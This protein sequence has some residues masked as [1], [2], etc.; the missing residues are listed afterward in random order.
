MIKFSEYVSIG[1]PDKIADYISQYLLDRYIERDPQTR[2]AVEVQIKDYQVTLGGEVSS[3]HHFSAQ[4]IR[5]F[6][7]AAVN[8]IGYTREYM[9]RWGAE[10][11]ICGDLLEV[12][13]L[14]SQ[15]SGDIAQGLDG[16]GDQGIFFGYCEFR[17]K[18]CGMPIDHHIAKRLCKELF[19]SGIGGLDIK[20][21]VVT[22]NDKVE[23]V[24]VAIPLL[25]ETSKKTV[26]HF[27]RSRVKGLYQLIINGTGRYVKH[28]SIADCGTTGRKLAVDF[29][30]GNCKIGGGCVD[31]ETEYLSPIGWR[32][33]SE[34]DGGLVG[35]IDD[36]FKLSFVKPDDYI[37]TH[38]KE[39]YSAEMDNTLSMVLSGNHNVYFRTSKGNF[40]KKTMSDLV[41]ATNKSSDGHHAEIPR[42]FSYDFNGDVKYENPDFVR[43]LIAHCA[44]GTVMAKGGKTYNC[45]IR[46]K[47]QC[48]IDRLRRILPNADVEFEE[49]EYSDGYAY[50][51]Y[52]LP[53]TSKF[54]SEHF[55][56]LNLS[57]NEAEIICNE[58]FKWDGS[59]IEEVFR[60]TKKE[61]ADFVQFVLSGYTGNVYSLITN[62]IEGDNRKS[63][64]YLVRKVKHKY[65]SPF[66]KKGQSKIRRI[67][68]QTVYCFTVLSG[69]LLVR[70]KNYIFVTG[71]SPWTKDASKADLTLNLAARRL[72]I[73]YSIKNKSDVKVALACCIGKQEVDFTVQDTANNVLAEGRMNINPAELRKEFKLD[74][75]IY[76]SMCRWGL[77]GEY[78]Q[79]KVWEL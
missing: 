27:V 35:Q 67:E 68:P 64:L 28:S 56:T 16:W 77:F 75:P 3:T 57:R 43:L 42:Y 39:V 32:K 1:H 53:N 11:T 8:E 21:Q 41:D 60:T 6:V 66:R 72:A 9:E 26:K 73:N 31:A 12:T 5:Q 62:K 51:Y 7:R 36:N 33:F 10:N 58:V 63:T 55:N 47:K 14:I 76:A 78:Q 49:R 30:G 20:T 45:R 54:I 79:D 69:L 29:Y 25:D 22:R 40:I 23:K 71:N 52:N 17:P 34:Y 37:K 61:D 13:S 46:V 74:T 59:D 19:E 50:F 38:A 48:K 15:Q 24:I 2:Y 18:T 65:C 4:E 44:D 70:R